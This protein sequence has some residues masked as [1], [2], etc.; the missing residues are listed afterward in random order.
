[1]AGMSFDWDDAKDA[2]NR[3]K[4]GISFEHAQEAFFDPK[5]V[6]ARDTVHS[7]TERRYY[8]FGRVGDGIATVRFTV[9]RR[10]IRIIGAGYWR[11]GKAAYEKANKI[12]G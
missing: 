5:R 2:T 3:S 8:C 11:K 1:M 10:R 6:I 12:R 4:H 9:R 7:G